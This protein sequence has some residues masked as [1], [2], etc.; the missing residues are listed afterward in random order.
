MV[1]PQS[2]AVRLWG[3]RIQGCEATLPPKLQAPLRSLG[4][5]PR[6]VCAERLSDPLTDTQRQRREF[7]AN[8]AGPTALKGDAVLAAVK[9]GLVETGA[10]GTSRRTPGLDGACA[11]R[12]CGFAGR[13]EETAIGR[14]KKLTLR[15]KNEKKR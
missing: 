6:R 14:T 10:R 11:R 15:K 7:A 1:E 5:L 2:A 12:H 9:A 13:D 8:A 4:A 3:H